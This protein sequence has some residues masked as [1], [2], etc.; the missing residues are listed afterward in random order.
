MY[1]FGF[2][3][4]KKRQLLLAR[5]PIG[6]KP[7]YFSFVNNNLVFASEVRAI[8][9]SRIVSSAVDK[10]ALSSFLAYGA[11]QE[12]CTIYKD[13]RAL[14]PGCYQV[15]DISD[16]N[17]IQQGKLKQHWDFPCV[18]AG[19][20][21]E[22]ALQGIQERMNE[23][24]RDHLVSDVPIGVFLS[25]GLDSTI[26]AGIAAH[27][28]TKVRTFTIGF[29]D[30][31]EMSEASLAKET[32]R[33]FGT[34]HT[35]INITGDD[36]EAM[37]VSWLG[38]LDQPSIDGLNTYIISQATR[39]E[40]IVVALSGLGGDELFGGYPKTFSTVPSIAAARQKLRW[41]PE[42]IWLALAGAATLGKSEAVVQKA[43]DMARSD[44]SLLQLYLH[45]RRVMSDKKLSMLGVDAGALGLLDNFMPPEIFES[46]YM[47]E[48]DD[49]RSISS[50]ESRFYM[51]NT[52]LRDSDTNGM[53]H[54][55]E[56]RVP[57]LDKRMLDFVYSI[58]GN[59]RLP[60]GKA[61]KHLIR[62]SF[63]N[64]LR[65]DLTKL[66]KRGFS[67]PIGRWIAGPMREMCEDA[68][69]HLKSLEI[70]RPEG[71]D[72]IWTSFMSSPETLRIGRV[73]GLCVLG[74]YYK[75]NRL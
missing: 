55:L 74:L 36:A 31:P 54:S 67:L 70:L 33:I 42:C 47:D 43:F 60:E 28:K 32:A 38:S 59:I 65:E 45:A 68:L 19:I 73:F 27:H 57:F 25:S 30:N 49:I 5:D 3:N 66:K 9:A 14:A 37:A 17:N 69:E 1:A 20:S 16:V 52:L 18:Q 39:A 40:G 10:Q 7:L 48:C 34:D 15:F 29:D 23:S 8:V 62:H 24:V 61:N 21:E 72:A 2:F 51:R 11:V 26:V 22:E 13:V 71:I 58:P 50:L 35:E 6:I 56:I 46:I 12:P 4:R 44:G 41:L 53:A 75:N 64:L 63:G